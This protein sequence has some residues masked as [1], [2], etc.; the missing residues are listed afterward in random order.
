VWVRLRSLA[1]GVLDAVF[2]VRFFFGVVVGSNLVERRWKVDAERDDGG[3]STIARRRWCGCFVAGDASDADA[4]VRE[5]FRVFVFVFGVRRGV[6][7]RVGFRS[8]E[9]RREGGDDAGGARRDVWGAHARG[10][11]VGGGA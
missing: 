6:R 9:P 10:W 5:N 3:D 7:E 4:M 1:R 8:R 2:D 11:S